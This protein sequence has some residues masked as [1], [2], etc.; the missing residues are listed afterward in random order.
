MSRSRVP[1]P[2]WDQY[3]NL[4][5]ANDTTSDVDNRLINGPSS[6]NF[7]RR[8][9][10][11]NTT[12]WT[13][14]SFVA[15]I[16]IGITI[17]LAI[18]VGILASVF[19][20]TKNASRD[21]EAY[22]LERAGGHAEAYLF[23]QGD[24]NK[25]GTKDHE[26]AGLIRF[27]AEDDG[28]RV[29]AEIQSLKPGSTHA[30]HIFE[31]TDPA[32]NELG[33]IYSPEPMP[34]GCPGVSVEHRVGD[35]GNVVANKF[36][37]AMYDAKVRGGASI[38]DIIGRTIAIHEHHDDCISQP[39][40]RSGKILSSGVIGLG[41][42]KQ[43]DAAPPQDDQQVGDTAAIADVGDLTEQ[44]ESETSSRTVDT[45]R[46]NMRGSPV[47]SAVASAVSGGGQELNNKE[48]DSAGGSEIVTPTPP[49]DASQND[50]L[51]SPIEVNN[52]AVGG[53]NDN[54][55]GS[56]SGSG[57]GSDSGSGS[58]SG[59]EETS[60]A[61]SSS[62]P[63]ASSS[64]SND[65]HS[66][67]TL[68]DAADGTEADATA[69]GAKSNDASKELPP[70]LPPS[71]SIVEGSGSEADATEAGAD[72][73]KASS[74]NESSPSSSNEEADGSEG[75][76]VLSDD[77]REKKET[78][79]GGVQTEGLDRDK[80]KSLLKEKI[81]TLM[82]AKEGGGG[83][84]GGGGGDD[85]TPS[86]SE[87]LTEEPGA[88]KEEPAAAANEQQEDDGSVPTPP[89]SG[90]EGSSLTEEP[91]AKK[92]E[93][94][95]ENEPQ[96]NDGS[97]PTPPASDGEGSSS[98]EATDDTTPA[99][100]K[101]TTPA[102]TAEE[103]EAIPASPAP[104]PDEPS[105]QG[106]PQIVQPAEP[107]AGDNGNDSKTAALAAMMQDDG[108][109]NTEV[110]SQGETPAAET[111]TAETPAGEETKTGTI[112]GCKSHD[113][114]AETIKNLYT[115]ILCR[116]PDPEGFEFWIKK[117]ESGTKVED[118]QA[119]MQQSEEAKSYG[120]AGCAEGSEQAQ[121]I[122]SAEDIAPVAQKEN[123]D[124]DPT[125]IL[126]ISTTVA[127]DTTVEV[128]TVAP[129]IA[130]PA[131]AMPVSAITAA[132][133]AALAAAPAADIV[134]STTAPA[135]TV[136]SA[137]AAPPAATPPLAPPSVPPSSTSTTKVDTVNDDTGPVD[138]TQIYGPI[139]NEDQNQDNG[140]VD[141]SN[142][143][144]EDDESWFDRR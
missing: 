127:P 24:V 122:E 88:K 27:Y 121:P 135:T 64:E 124:D 75:G 45:L 96:E 114:A 84:G 140:D 92:E 133:T 110:N 51:Y 49:T 120:E 115:T 105:E 87:G 137:S 99:A 109:E 74:S 80:L 132:I 119:T 20:E 93:P 62:D 68:N 113:E 70:P 12:K 60:A 3:D 25:D 9:R 97:V 28:F 142:E 57:R 13:T 7:S 118:I 53:D 100:A 59:G 104:A 33:T 98:I 138:M 125:A 79:L 86:S 1:P 67:S 128:T 95:A 35:L 4:N 134:A 36:G 10:R 54:G 101:D 65:S 2:R 30:L 123:E 71:P 102:S 90:G 48:G 77:S 39:L 5:N 43:S 61:L 40:G 11:K 26:E 14:W 85:A 107:P 66:P 34:H 52:G 69:A 8:N 56:G 117:C 21:R 42:P 81:K 16:F 32:T 129:A 58:G 31:F 130:T 44:A 103:T 144:T 29:V 111:S 15:C 91:A 108:T 17:F 136:P 50:Q 106:T 22:L 18:M 47:A 6:S 78:M 83:G 73:N 126:E 82:D 37:V 89:P 23:R 19:Y 94:A 112:E 72:S 55:S 63:A 46:T 38:M 141:E 139:M 116:G 76:S 41:N 143:S 131:A